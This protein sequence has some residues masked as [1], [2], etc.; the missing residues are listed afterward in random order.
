MRTFTIKRAYEIELECGTIDE[1][2]CEITLKAYDRYEAEEKAG[3]I[4][5]DRARY[6]EDRGEAY[7]HEY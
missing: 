6:L 3:D 7:F 5:Y 2:I 1:V 4:D